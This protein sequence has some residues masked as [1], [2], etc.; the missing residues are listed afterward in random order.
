MKAKMVKDYS[1]LAVYGSRPMLTLG[2]YEER[3]H[4]PTQIVSDLSGTS[5]K[6]VTV[7]RSMDQTAFRLLHDQCTESL[8]LWN[9]EATETC[10]LL[11]ECENIPL[12]LERR[13]ALQAQRVRENDAQVTHM[14]VRQRLFDLARMGFNASDLVYGA[15]PR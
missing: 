1:G 2:R 10:K 15:F 8:Q 9:V 12:S 7:D 6:R 3:H 5:Q 14:E 13:S 4:R 11:G